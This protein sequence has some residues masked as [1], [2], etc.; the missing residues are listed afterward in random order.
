LSMGLFDSAQ[1]LADAEGISKSKLSLYLGFAELPDTVVEKF[2]DITKVPYRL[3]YEINKTCKAIGIEE[4]IKII[5]DIESGSLSRTDVQN[6]QANVVTSGSNPIANGQSVSQPSVLSIPLDQKADSMLASW[7][8]DNVLETK[9]L[10]GKQSDAQIAS[11]FSDSAT[12]LEQSSDEK[13]ASN[14]ETITVNNDAGD[15]TSTHA[16]IQAPSSLK[17]ILLSSSG[18]KLFTYNNASRGWLIRIDPE[19]SKKIDED[20]MK[21]LGTLIESYCGQSK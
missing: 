1:Q 20:F 8:Q 4:T 5:P 19:I 18:R 3:G 13:Q 16:I 11:I 15:A 10:V 9:G 17:N 14:I 21:Q 6:M 7:R 2:A 12:P